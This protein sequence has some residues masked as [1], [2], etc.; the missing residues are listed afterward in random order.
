MT[1][2]KQLYKG[3][4]YNLEKLLINGDE[5]EIKGIIYTAN[6]KGIEKEKLIDE[7][8]SKISLTLSQ[9]ILIS[10]QINGFKNKNKNEYKK[11]LEYYN[12]HEHINLSNF[13]QKMTNSKNIV[14]TFS[15][16]LNAIQNISDINNTIYG[17]CEKGC[18][19]GEDG[20]TCASCNLTYEFRESCASCHPG[21]YLLPNGPITLCSNCYEDS[22]GKNNCTE[23]EYIS[24]ETR[25][26]SCDS[27]SFLSDGKCVI[28]CTENCLNCSYENEKWLCAQCKDKYFLNKTGE[29]KICQECPDECKNCLRKDMC[30]ECLEEYKLINGYCDKYCTIG[31]N[32]QCMSC[33]FD[34]KNKCKVNIYM[35]IK[36]KANII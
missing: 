19:L 33:D 2:K 32:N 29:G 15:N 3:V 10:L 6:K 12:Q 16:K 8:L 17:Q 22:L 7:I 34:E 5:E 35:V 36:L 27:K 24:G 18:E 4:N 30:T 14:Y 20:S 9:D 13:I 1:K 25:C 11:I 28:S 23:C 26:T 31:A 21:Y